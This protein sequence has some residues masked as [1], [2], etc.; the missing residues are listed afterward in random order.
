M[1]NA[2]KETKELKPLNNIRKMF[3]SSR[4][5]VIQNIELSKGRIKGEKLERNNKDKKD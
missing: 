1:K 4:K 2:K 5:R 3:R